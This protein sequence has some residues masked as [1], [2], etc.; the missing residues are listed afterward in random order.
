MSGAALFC[1]L[2]TLVLYAISKRLYQRWPCPWLTPALVVSVLTVAMVLIL[3]IPYSTYQH[4]TR[5]VVWLLGPATVAFA[6]PIYEY[7]A[8]V[9]RHGLALALG[10]VA[11]MSMA[12]VSAWVLARLFHFDAT[13]SRSLL[14]RS[15]STPF[16]LALSDHVGGSRQIVAVL[17][18]MTGLVGMF[19][20]DTVLALLKLRSTVAHGAAFGASSH[21]F[22]T[23]R[24]RERHSEEGVVASLTMVIAGVAMVLVGPALVSGL[25]AV[26]GAP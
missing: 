7:R 24:A 8:V 15:I 14:V 1:L 18:V 26:F 12:L 11:G 16:A 10:V 19:A 4:D 13:L 17:T 3:G 23:A 20:G 9:R 2:W 21:G 5:W 6:V 22:G 25:I